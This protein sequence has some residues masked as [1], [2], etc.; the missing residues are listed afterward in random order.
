MPLDDSDWEKMERL[1]DKKL[2]NV[3]KRVTCLETGFSM[4]ARFQRTSVLEAVKE[5]HDRVLRS[6]FDESSLLV[7]A[8]LSENND[9]RLSRPMLRCTKTDVSQLI[10]G[11]PELA[12][13]KY[14]IEP[15]D[16]GFRLLMASWSPQS[17]RKWAALIIKQARTLLQDD[18]SAYLQYDKPYTLRMMQKEA[19]KF[20]SVLH[21]RGGSAVASKELKNGFIVVNGVRLA[22]EY[23]VPCPSY[24]DRLADVVLEKI[25]SW[26]G[27]APA[28]PTDGVLME[29]FGMA[30]AAFKGVV[31]LEDVPADEDDYMMAT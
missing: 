22:P 28:G 13:V 8:P 6:M 31:D 9:G 29:A 26:R 18:L 17:R 3:G 27:R 10:S 19:Y 2:N 12:D 14:E 1:L 24:W 30:Y 5:K 25:K 23:L 16:V 4:S 15:T 21:K 7:V 11:I 20:L